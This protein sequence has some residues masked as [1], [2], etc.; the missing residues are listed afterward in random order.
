[1]SESIVGAP[2]CHRIMEQGS[3]FFFSHDFSNLMLSQLYDFI[4]DNYFNVRLR[5]SNKK[6]NDDECGE[7]QMDDGTI[8]DNQDKHLWRDAYAYDYIYRPKELENY[9]PYQ[10]LM[11]YIQM[12]KKR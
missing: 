1:M 3:R 11:E 4:D 7:E 9:S 5:R 2:M 10:M 8:E 12:P 6:N